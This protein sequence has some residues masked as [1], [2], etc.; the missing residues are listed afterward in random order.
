MR[1]QATRLYLWAQRKALSERAPYWVG[2]LFFFELALFL[3]M[4]A[5]F[6]FFCL[7]NRRRSFLYAGVATFASTASAL[8]GYGLG[9][10][11]WDLLS[12]YLVPYCLSEVSLHRMMHH[13]QSY[14]AGA[15]FL[16]A[17]VPFPL[18][19]V[20]LAAGIFQLGLSAFILWFLTARILRF[21]L[22]GSAVLLWGES[23]RIF[24]ERHFHRLLV[25]LG[26]KIL[27][28]LLFFWAMTR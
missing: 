10:F 24:V 11:L 9:Y 12:P 6:L 4:D 8:V 23:V 7:Q 19:L 14:E 21:F 1:A 22:I 25:I 5:L 17:L 13:L 2:V 28:L 15:V 16:G 20:S 27:T 3:P 18:K 26:A